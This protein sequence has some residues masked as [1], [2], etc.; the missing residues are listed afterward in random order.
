M[1][2]PLYIQHKGLIY[3]IL[4]TLCVSYKEK[5]TEKPHP[6]FVLRA[7]GNPFTVFSVIRSSP[8][9]PFK[10]ICNPEQLIPVQ[11]KACRACRPKVQRG[12]SGGFKEGSWLAFIGFGNR[13]AWRAGIA[14]PG[15]Q[16]RQI[17]TGCCYPPDNADR[18]KALQ[19]VYLQGR[20]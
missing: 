10:R 11:L 5:H 20:A 17:P 3:K 9:N 12:F 18:F 6:C 14:N 1:A 13:Y 15:Q 16:T 7:C 4:Y 8:L 19:A 2:K